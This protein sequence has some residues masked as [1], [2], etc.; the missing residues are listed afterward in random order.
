MKGKGFDFDYV[1]ESGMI[2]KGNECITGYFY[3]IYPLEYFETEQEARFAAIGHIAILE[4]E[5]QS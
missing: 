1:I 2:Q 5:G 4:K 3:I